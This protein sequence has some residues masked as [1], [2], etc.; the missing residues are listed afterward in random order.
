MRIS[1]VLIA[2]L[3]VVVL[4]A[5]QGNTASVIPY[6]EVPPEGDIAR[7][8]QLFN[9]AI[10]LAPSCASCHNPDANAVPDLTGYGAVAGTRVEG[11]SAHEYTFYSI[12]EPGRYVLPGYGNAMY[13]QYDEKMTPEQMADLIAYLLSL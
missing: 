12:A 11:E 3:C 1:M 8:E 9:E 2:I 4:T 6:T 7:G 13:N 10:N 5:C